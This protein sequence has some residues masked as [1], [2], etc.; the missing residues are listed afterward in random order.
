[1][2]VRVERAGAYSMWGRV[3]DSDGIGA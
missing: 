1:V 2:T 3:I